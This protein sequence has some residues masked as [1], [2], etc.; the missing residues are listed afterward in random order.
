MSI[1]LIA[2]AGGH[3]KVVADIALK[4][5]KYSQIYFLEDDKE[6][7]ESMGISVIGSVTA[8]TE[9]F[10]KKVEKSETEVVMAIGNSRTRMEKQK[11]FEEAGFCIA[12]M[13]HPSAVIGEDVVIG[14]GTVVMANAVINSGSRIGK[15]CIINTAASVDHDNYIGDYVHIS[16]GSHLAGEVSIGEHVWI[17]A[18][19]IVSNDLSVCKECVI[20]AGAVV[21]KNI[22]QQ[23]T[24]IGVPAHLLIREKCCSVR[25]RN[26][27]ISERG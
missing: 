4:L 21:V 16:V 8:D 23:G 25:N 2:G 22:L 27:R 26:A 17:G 5:N 24:Y 20:G 9:Q 11:L 3:G 19:A 18:G 14:K 12:T 13:I 10:F 1:L 15:G 7:K 6:K